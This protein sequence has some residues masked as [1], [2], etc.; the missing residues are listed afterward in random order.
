MDTPVKT[1]VKTDKKS[2]GRLVPTFTYDMLGKGAIHPE[3]HL[4]KDLDILGSE[5]GLVSDVDA[6]KLKDTFKDQ[7]I[8]IDEEGYKPFFTD[9]APPPPKQ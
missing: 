8:E 3:D 1:T 5:D 7:G 9:G 2:D 6:K 4:I